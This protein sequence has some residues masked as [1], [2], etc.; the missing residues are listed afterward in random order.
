MAAVA[1]PLDEVEY[2]RGLLDTEGRGRLVEDHEL[3]L[4]EHRAGDGHGLALAAGERGDRDAH[5]RD[6]D[7]QRG[8]ELAGAALHLDLVEDAALADLPAEVEVAD[9]VDVVAQREVLVDGRD[10]EILGVVGLVDL[11][12]AAFPLDDTVIDGVHAGDRLDQRGLSGAVVAHQGDHF[13]GVDLKLYVGER[14]DGTE[15]LGDPSQRQ[16]GRSGHVN[17]LLRRLTGGDAAPG[18][19]GAEVE[20]ESGGCGG[21]LSG[22]RPE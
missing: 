10:A 16:H 18:E 9:D 15:P 11:Y 14:L 1:Q 21:V 3:G 8:E 19:G 20:Q 13:T 6:A 22:A 12:G 17:H 7:G 2:L 5:A 4:A